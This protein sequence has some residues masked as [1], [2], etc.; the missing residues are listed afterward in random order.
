MIDNKA[1]YRNRERV[2]KK[3]NYEENYLK[4]KIIEV[5]TYERIFSKK[6]PREINERD[7]LI[8]KMSSHECGSLPL[9]IRI[10]FNVILVHL[11]ILLTC[12]LS[13]LF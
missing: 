3:K 5:R 10:I 8:H 9:A 4:R 2:R 13:V 7:S 12:L 1:Q 6:F 11:F